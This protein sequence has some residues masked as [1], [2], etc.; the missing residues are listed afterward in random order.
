LTLNL[1][2][3]YITWIFFYFFLQRFKN[4]AR[5]TC[6]PSS[7]YNKLLLIQAEEQ[8]IDTQNFTGWTD[9]TPPRDTNNLSHCSFVTF[10]PWTAHNNC[11]LWRYS[12][13]TFVRCT[14][15]YLSYLG[16]LCLTLGGKRRKNKTTIS[17]CKTIQNSSLGRLN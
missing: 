11:Y 3:Q 8:N 10:S 5:Q 2:N 14:G 16:C 17:W 7:T 13:S 12:L 6:W 1:P 4:T 15:I 9:Y